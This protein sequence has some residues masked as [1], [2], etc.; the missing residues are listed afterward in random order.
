MIDDLLPYL[1]RNEIIAAFERSPGKEIVSGKFSSVESSAALAANTFGFFIEQPRILP[2]LPGTQDCGWPA[3]Y[4]GVEISAPFPWWPRGQHPWLDV[5]IATETHVIGIESKRYEPYR[6]K[7]AG[8]FSSTY[9]RDVWG[10][11][12]APFEQ[13]RDRLAEGSTSFDRIDAVQLVK[14]AFGLR[15]EGQR[16]G[17]SA[18]LLYLYAEPEAWG[19]GRMVNPEDRKIHAREAECFAREVSGA[20][21]AFT[22]CTY[23]TLLNVFRETADPWL[24]H[25]ADMVDA[26]FRP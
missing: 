18:V 7:S 15:T 20:E 26:K 25:H 4:V 12:M 13:M 6:G 5:F 21:V 19:N 11:G 17:K 10:S 23:R 16:R 3:T 14:H 9:W 22:A 1:P 2:A 8:T 24:C